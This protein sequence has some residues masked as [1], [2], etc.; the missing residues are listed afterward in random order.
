MRSINYRVEEHFQGDIMNN[1]DSYLGPKSVR[2]FYYLVLK[3][4]IPHKPGVGLTGEKRGCCSI[5]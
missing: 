4:V 1:N 3:Q 5:R 2:M